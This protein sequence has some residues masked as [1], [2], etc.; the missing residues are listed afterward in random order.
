MALGHDADCNAA[1]AGA[2]LGY[3]LGFRHLAAQ[4]QF[5]LPD[6]YVNKTR[7]SLPT[8]CR[9]SEQAETLLRLAERVILD[10][11]GRRLER[12]GE[13]TFEVRLQEPRTVAP[14]TD[15]APDP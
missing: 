14:L 9:V 6:R 8:E 1:T 12:D 3:R 7:P 4:P 11:G 15:P 10:H 2:A 13:L 5:R